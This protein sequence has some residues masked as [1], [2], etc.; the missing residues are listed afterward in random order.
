MADLHHI[1]EFLNTQ[2]RVRDYE[3]VAHNGLQVENSGKVLKICCGVDASMEFFEKAHTAG[4]DMLICHHGISWGDSLKR[5]EGINYRR[6]SYLIGHDMALYACH[7]PLDAHAGIGNNALLCSALGIRNRKLF[8][9]YHGKPI[10]YYGELQR[11]EQYSRF[12]RR[13]EALLG[14]PVRALNFGKKTV[15]KIGVVSGGGSEW[16]EEASRLNLDLFLTGEATLSGYNLAKDCGMNVLFGGHYATE[17]FG[18]RALGQAAG[19]KFHVRSEFI[20]LGLDL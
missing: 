9:Y 7:I 5:I 13:V 12:L 6:L 19:K 10:G 18:V 2:M 1:V 20:D 17:S 15:R 3:D 8:G 4:A 11:T 14:G 16:I